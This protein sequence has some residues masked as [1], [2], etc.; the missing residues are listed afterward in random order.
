MVVAKCAGEDAV[1]EVQASGWRHGERIF[2]PTARASIDIAMMN[3]SHRRVY[4]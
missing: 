1:Q 3:G 4:E 2:G